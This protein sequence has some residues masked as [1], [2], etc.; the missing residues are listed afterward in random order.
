MATIIVDSLN[1]YGTDAQGGRVHDLLGT[2]C[3]PYI[4]KY[5]TGVDRDVH[6]HSN[7]TRA[8]KPFGL[9][10]FDVHDVLNVFQCTGLN[11]EDKYFM[12]ASPATKETYI[13]FF[14]EQPLLAA[15]STCPGGDLSLR[16]WGEGIPEG[17]DPA[18]ACCRPLK[19]E[20]F[21]L[22]E[23]VLNNWKPW[24]GETYK[25]DHGFKTMGI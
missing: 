11:A 18:L 6:C 25:G 13:E 20:V 22:P 19:V 9:T 8:I 12:K 17:D 1:S 14:A 10:E 23:S 2:R 15:L 21:K 24:V 3:D 7:L 16:M 5:L 4:N